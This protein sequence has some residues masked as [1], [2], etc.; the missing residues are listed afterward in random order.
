MNTTRMDPAARPRRGTFQVFYMTDEDFKAWRNVPVA[1]TL[2][3]CRTRRI[4]FVHAP[5]V[6]IAIIS[7]K[8]IGKHVW[9]SKRST[10]D[11]VEQRC[12]DKNKGIYC[13]KIYARGWEASFMRGHT[14]SSLN[15]VYAFRVFIRFCIETSFWS[16]W[17]QLIMDVKFVCR[18]GSSFFKLW[19][20]VSLIRAAKD[21]GI[22]SIWSNS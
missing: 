22:S 17:L 6:V 9:F 8:T 12:L 2:E 4:L 20:N 1:G 18:G 21:S 16:V 15:Y 5:I 7:G 14:D 19:E 3:S 11:I 13:G 10:A